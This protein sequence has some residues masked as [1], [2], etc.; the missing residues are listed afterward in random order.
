MANHRLLAPV[1]AQYQTMQANGRTY[2]CEPG[3]FLDVPNFDAAILE[4]NGW[5]FV[6]LS[7]TTAERTAAP[8]R[9][10]QFYDTSL[11]KFIIFDG[12]T[13]CDCAGGAT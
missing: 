4:A 10:Q 7:G 9:G 13:W 1:N 3:S 5:V 8:V 11:S 2:S 12:A 6:A